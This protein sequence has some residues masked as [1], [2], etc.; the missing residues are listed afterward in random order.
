MGCSMC[1]GASQPE[2]GTLVGAGFWESEEGTGKKKRK[3]LVAFLC[4]TCGNIE[5]CAD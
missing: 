2:R 5:L 4:P 1:A 3:K